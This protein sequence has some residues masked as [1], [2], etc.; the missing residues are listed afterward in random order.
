[1]LQNFT[2]G[3]W[4]IDHGSSPF[5]DNGH[6]IECNGR[7]IAHVEGWENDEPEVAESNA[8]LIAASPELFHYLYEAHQ[9]LFIVDKH[10]EGCKLAVAIANALNKATGII[11]NTTGKEATHE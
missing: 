4:T 1:M 7:Q 10:Y 11:T 9:L 5:I 6:T 3:E 8:A 2:K